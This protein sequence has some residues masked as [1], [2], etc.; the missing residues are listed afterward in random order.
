MTI[1]CRAK[2]H[3]VEKYQPRPERLLTGADD[4][5]GDYYIEPALR[6][7]MRKISKKLRG[8]VMF[9]WNNGESIGIRVPESNYLHAFLRVVTDR[10]GKNVYAVESFRIHTEKAVDYNL[11]GYTNSSYSMRYSS[12]LGRVLSILYKLEPITV[13]EQVVVSVRECNATG[14]NKMSKHDRA[15]SGVADEFVKNIAPSY[16]DNDKKADLIKFVATAIDSADMGVAPILSESNP[17]V[18][19][20]REFV[21]KQRETT[22]TISYLGKRVCIHVLNM[23]ERLY[24]ALQRE[25]TVH[26]V[27]VPKLEGLPEAVQRHIHTVNTIDG[28]DCDAGYMVGKQ[29]SY[30]SGSTFAEDHYMLFVNEEELGNVVD[31][32]ISRGTQYAD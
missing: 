6:E 28:H 9:Y 13:T 17:I 19:A 11:F 15:L 14:E 8:R 30:S 27:E 5:N 21:N 7:A 29:E 10:E 12:N 18:S 22:E 31:Q 24:L 32:V 26:F 1:N 3:H 4:D 2:P 23:A 20:F 25:N 16:Y